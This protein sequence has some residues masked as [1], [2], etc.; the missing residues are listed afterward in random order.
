[1]YRDQT[2][3]QKSLTPTFNLPRHFYLGP[4]R[5]PATSSH[6]AD[7]NS[8]TGLDNGYVI[9]KP[10]THPRIVGGFWK[11]PVGSAWDLSRL[12]AT[13]KVSFWNLGVRV[14]ETWSGWEELMLQVARAG[15][16][17]KGMEVSTKTTTSRTSYGMRCDENNEASSRIAARSIRRPPYRPNLGWSHGL[18]T[19]EMPRKDPGHVLFIAQLDGP[20]SL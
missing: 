18:V 16:V 6:I 11:K 5:P 4:W 1:M 10:A 8:P 20:S 9:V 19:L 3:P 15:G 7:I 2:K 13:S 14:N 12:K 17:N